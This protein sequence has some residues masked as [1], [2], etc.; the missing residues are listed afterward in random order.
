EGVGEESHPRFFVSSERLC[1][2]CAFTLTA[3]RSDGSGEY[4]IAEIDRDFIFDADRALVLY[5][6]LGPIVPGSIV[7]FDLNTRQSRE[8]ALPVAAQVLLD[9]VQDGTGHLV[10]YVTLG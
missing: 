4:E 9:Q 3:R 5:P 6:K 10:A 8:I 7:L 2:G 1:R